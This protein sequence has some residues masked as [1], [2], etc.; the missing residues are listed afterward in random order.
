MVTTLRKPKTI[1]Q[2][3]ATFT[4]SGHVDPNY[5]VP[6][7]QAARRRLDAHAAAHV[8]GNRLPQIDDYIHKCGIE[9]PCLQA[10]LTYAQWSAAAEYKL[11]ASKGIKVGDIPLKDLEPFLGRG[12]MPC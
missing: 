4:L 5:P 11:L 12:R 9:A 6:T 8:H 10:S 1:D 3:V 2:A 7:W